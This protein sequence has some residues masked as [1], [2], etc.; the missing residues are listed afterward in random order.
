MSAL[1]GLDI[2]LW[3]LKGECGCCYLYAE[4]RANVIIVHSSQARCTDLPITGRQG[5]GYAQSLRLDRW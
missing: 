4:Q 5:S 3:D 2:A 1:A